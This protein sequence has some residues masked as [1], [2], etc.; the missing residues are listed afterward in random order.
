MSI[1]QGVGVT[2]MDA[3]GIPAALAAVGAADLILLAVGYSNA[4]VEREGADHNYTGLPGLQPSFVAQVLAAAGARP[5]VLL[6]VNAGQIALDTLPAL[7]PA[8]VEAFYPAFGAPAILRQLFGATNL[9]GRLPYTMYEAAF[10][11]RTAL[12]DASVSGAP[13]NA[14]RTHRY[15]TGSP[16]FWFG[17]GLSYSTFSLTC[18]AAP[19]GP[20]A[21]GSGALSLSLQ[22]TSAL[23]AGSPDGDQILLVYHSVG[24]DVVGQVGGAHPIPRR[25]LRNFDRLA[26]GSSSGPAASQWQF[27]ALDLALTNAVGASVLY[28]GTHT[29]TV[30]GFGGIAW[31]QNFTVTGSATILSAPPPYY[32]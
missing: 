16:C 10:A 25:T 21:A 3:S 4:L 24:A 26:L 12:G 18:A 9:W 28:P 23:A 15:Y 6:L 11:T 13:G 32:D 1:A 27:T 17:D 31:A 14:T 20:F 5:V 19:A 29:L 22:C 8:V 2:S 30:S 7:P